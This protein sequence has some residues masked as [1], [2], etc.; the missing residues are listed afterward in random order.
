MWYFS[1]ISHLN[2]NIDVFATCNCF[3]DSVK[4]VLLDGFF[5]TFLVILDSLL[6]CVGSANWSFLFST[7]VFFVD[8]T[9]GCAVFAI[10]FG[11]GAAVKLKVFKIEFS[12]GCTACALANECAFSSDDQCFSFRFSC[13][14]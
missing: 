8:P 12:F 4:F 3:I 1:I 7:I 5:K 10:E 11:A 14:I 2:I 13:E 6:N 9:S